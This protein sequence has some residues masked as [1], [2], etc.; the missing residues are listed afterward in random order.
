MITKITVKPDTFAG[1]I[2]LFKEIDL[3]KLRNPKIILLFGPNGIGKSTLINEI[4]KSAAKNSG[5]G[6]TI[7]HDGTPAVVYSYK[8]KKDNFQRRE[9]RTIHESYDPAFLTERFNANILSEGQS[10]IY[11]VFH[12]INNLKPNT[13]C[14]TNPG[15]DTIVLLDEIDSGISIDNIDMLMRKLK[16]A[17]THRTDLQV[18]LSFNSPRVLKY[19]SEVI[20]LYDGSVL[21]LKTEDDMLAEIKR[22]Q[23]EFNKLRKNSNGTPK[24]LG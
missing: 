9:A 21:T 8:N 4:I 10:I 6:L 17:I 3:Q 12:L 11:S 13:N 23:K 18:F 7:E 16:Y 15:K 14:F 22:H 19:F 24:I 1:H 20:S 5:S 2:L